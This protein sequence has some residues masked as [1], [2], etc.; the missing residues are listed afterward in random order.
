MVV[1]LLNINNEDSSVPL[2]QHATATI[3][4]L[5]LAGDL[6]TTDIK[7]FC[8]VVLLVLREVTKHLPILPI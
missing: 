8:P 3:L 5:I 6:V 2:F 1:V 7:L 4:C